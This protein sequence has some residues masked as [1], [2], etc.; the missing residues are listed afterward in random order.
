MFRSSCLWSRQ[1]TDSPLL[2]VIIWIKNSSYFR[3]MALLKEVYHWGWALR[4]ESLILLPIAFFS[5][6]CFLCFLLA[7]EDVRDQLTLE[8]LF[9]LWDLVLVYFVTVLF[10]ISCIVLCYVWV[11][12]HRTF[13]FL[14]YSLLCM[15]HII[16]VVAMKIT[17]NIQKLQHTVLN[18]NSL[19][20]ETHNSCFLTVV[21]H[22]FLLLHWDYNFSVNVS[23]S[24][25]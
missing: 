5:F 6:H 13:T 22:P 23:Q 7:F 10:F 4:V 19:P 16:F 2:A 21:P 18:L 15:F 25:N 11:I 14:S 24:I 17:F 12:L 8:A 1:F 9:P 20:W 3:G